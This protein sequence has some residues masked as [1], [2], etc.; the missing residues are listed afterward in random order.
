MRGDTYL[1]SVDIF[2]PELHYGDTAV[3]GLDIVKGQKVSSMREP[4]KH[5]I[6]TSS[7]DSR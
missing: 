6:W 3:N 1:E 4:N 7:S 2:F 5:V